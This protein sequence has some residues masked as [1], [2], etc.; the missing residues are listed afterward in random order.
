MKLKA[1][2]FIRRFL[3]HVLPLGFVRIRHYGFLAN[4]VCREK[5]ELCRSLLAAA[6]SPEPVADGPVS[7]RDAATEKQPAAHVCPACDEGRMVIIE[8]IRPTPGGRRRQ[9]RRPSIGRD[10]IH[11]ET[12]GERRERPDESSPVE[13]PLEGDRGFPAFRTGSHAQKN[14]DTPVGGPAGHLRRPHEL[15][16]DDPMS[17]LRRGSVAAEAR[18]L[19]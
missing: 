14:G 8:M 2:E 10:T 1:V 19:D 17:G 15:S 18:A 11:P 9:A 3:M 6:T 7:D 5:L 13:P 4:R 12:V 16:R